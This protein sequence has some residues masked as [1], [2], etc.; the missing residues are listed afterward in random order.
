MKLEVN[1]K[2]NSGK[3]TNTWRLGNILLKNEWVNQNIKEIFKKY[4]ETSENENKWVQNLW[5]AAKAVL[6]KKSIA[7]QLYLKKQEKTQIYNL[8]LHLKDLKTE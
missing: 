4:I 7:I 3:N 2:K 8:T 5:D 6:R 1:H